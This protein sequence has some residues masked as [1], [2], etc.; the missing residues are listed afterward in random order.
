M[1]DILTVLLLTSNYELESAELC[2]KEAERKIPSTGLSGGSLY[3]EVQAEQS[4][5]HLPFIC[6]PHLVL[7]HNHKDAW[8]F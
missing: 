8:L 2:Y 3:S 4:K 1:P 7:E 6:V 5:G